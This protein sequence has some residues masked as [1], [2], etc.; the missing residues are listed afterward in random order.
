MCS[1]GYWCGVVGAGDVN[2]TVNCAAAVTVTG[3][4]AVAVH[5]EKF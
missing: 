2:G 1:D 4:V 3:A 5:C